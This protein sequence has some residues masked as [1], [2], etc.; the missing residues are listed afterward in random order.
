MQKKMTPTIEQ[1]A[2]KTRRRGKKYTLYLT[3]EIMDYID[4]RAGKSKRSQVVDEILRSHVEQLK[5]KKTE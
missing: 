4:K 1:L 5:D 2:A 3:I